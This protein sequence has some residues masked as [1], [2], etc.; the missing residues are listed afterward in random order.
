M[1]RRSELNTGWIVRAVAGD[2][3]SRVPG[4]FPAVVPGSVHTDLM[5]A[6]VIPDPYLDAVEEEL[7]WMYGIDWRYSTGLDVAPPEDGE[8]VDLVFGGIDTVG[9][10]RL[11]DGEHEV[12]L[13]RKIK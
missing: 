10:V 11:R 2:P 9:T 12:E 8:R 1:M 6:G 7:R 13:G 5:A 3:S 4:S